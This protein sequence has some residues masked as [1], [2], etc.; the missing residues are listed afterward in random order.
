[1]RR[2]ILP[3]L[4]LFTLCG[5]YAQEN[6]VKVGSI[7]LSPYIASTD[8]Y[9]PQARQLLM[10]KMRQMITQAGL[11]SYGLDEKF[12]MTAHVQSMGTEVTGTIPQKTAVR[13]SVSF[14]IGNGISGTLFTSYQVEVK[15]IGDSEDKA[16]LSAIRKIPVSDAGIQRMIAEGKSRIQEFYAK[17]SASIV[18]AA[19]AQATAG[20]YVE[21]IQ[22]LLAIPSSSKYYAEAQQLI[23]Q[24]GVRY[25]ARVNGELLNKARA[26]WSASLTRDGARLAKSYLQQM[27]NPTASELAEARQLT[28]TMSQKLQDDDAAEWRLLEKAMDQEHERMLARIDQ[29]TTEAVAAAAV[30]VARY[31]AQPRRVYHYHWW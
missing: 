16:Y 21:A 2:F 19:K 22:S 1:M 10:D 7:V 27:V 4:L 25:Y 6:R 3:I 26:A 11:A 29:E 23:G 18:A 24:Y 13:L 30:A 14:Y 15:G 8:S 28:R 20:S 31:E 5:V 17:E 9:T 12:I